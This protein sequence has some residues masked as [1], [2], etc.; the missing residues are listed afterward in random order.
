VT[1]K[2]K[3]ARRDGVTVP[4][5]AY[6]DVSPPIRVPGVLG[7]DPV[8]PIPLPSSVAARPRPSAR[9]GSARVAGQL[10]TFERAYLIEELRRISI[11]A[12]SLLALI[13]VLTILL[14]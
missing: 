9:P 11:T 10:P 13:I 7:Q 4:A 1:R 14:R 6:I 8:G 3:T 2:R 12:G 5:D